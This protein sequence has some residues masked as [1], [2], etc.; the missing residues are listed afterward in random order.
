MQ[1]GQEKVISGAQH[2]AYKQKREEFNYKLH[3]TPYARQ[4][5]STSGLQCV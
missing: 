1:A 2:G 4:V 5:T 3:L